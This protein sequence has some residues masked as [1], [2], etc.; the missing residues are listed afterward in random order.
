[1]KRLARAAVLLAPLLVCCETE[2]A[3]ERLVNS[4][5]EDFEC[6]SGE[7]CDEDEGRCVRESALSPYTFYVQVEPT[8]RPELV[9]RSSEPPRSLE[10]EAD[11]GMITVPRAARVRG[12]VSGADG[13]TLEAEVSFRRTPGAPMYLREPRTAFTRRADGDRFAALLEPATFYDAFVVPL[14]TAASSYPPRMFQIDTSEQ[15]DVPLS[16]EAQITVRG[17]LLPDQTLRPLRSPFEG[18]RVRLRAKS[19]GAVV[20]SLDTLDP[21]GEFTIRVKKEV[22]DNLPAYEL[23]LD[24]LKGA[25]PWIATLAIDGRRLSA[26]G[27]ATVTI[28]AIPPPVPMRVRVLDDNERPIPADLTFVSSYQ[29]PTGD[30]PIPERDWCRLRNQSSSPPTCSARLSIPVPFG[31]EQFEILPGNYAVY[32][33]PRA[34]PRGQRFTALSTTES[35]TPQENG[36]VLGPVGY[37]ELPRSRRYEGRIISETGG[38]M[39]DVSVEARA[40]SVPHPTFGELAAYNRSAAAVSAADGTYQLALDVG[41]YDL[42]AVPPAGSGFPWFVLP[43]RFVHQGGKYDI[44]IA[45]PV[46]VRGQVVD[47]RG[48][49]LYAANIE[50]FALVSG[51]QGDRPIRIARASSDDA[52]T[53]V[54][55]MPPQIGDAPPPSL[56]GGVM[57]AGRRSDGAQR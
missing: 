18:H 9:S 54:L 12:T 13:G 50:A 3:G 22:A 29:A 44:K 56:D 38:A 33:T 25:P 26:Q 4:C 16:Y 41:S 10:S 17:T 28:P 46:L 40:L 47:D 11:L 35:V 7:S 48:A 6:S 53:F 39:P 57:D 15:R 34:G 8:M 37:E 45:T 36:E 20:S 30:V 5:S 51:E 42:V 52:G 31:D 21:N 43:N 19:D 55:Y 2:R 24:L 23:V 14:G 27:T 1:M 49:P 32:V